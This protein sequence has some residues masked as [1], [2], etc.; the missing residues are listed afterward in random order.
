MEIENQSENIQPN[1][2]ISVNEDSNH[3][4]VTNDVYK[5]VNTNITTINTLHKRKLVRKKIKG[6]N[7]FTVFAIII[8]I[9]AIITVILFLK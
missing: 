4:N 1:D 2:F 3:D 5:D 9:I 7:I 8:L 6:I